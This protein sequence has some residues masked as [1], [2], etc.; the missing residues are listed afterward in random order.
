MKS[1]MTLVKYE[2]QKIFKKKSVIFALILALFVSI[3]SVCGTLFGDYYLDGRLFES[4]YEAMVKDRDYARSL[5][6]RVI[7]TGL[8]LEAAAA[9]ATIPDNAPVY[10]ATDEYQQNARTYSEIYN[11]ARQIYS[12]PSMRFNIESLSGL[13]QEQAGQFYHLQNEKISQAVNNT[14]MSDAA[15]EIVL[16]RAAQIKTPLTFSYTDGYTRFFAVLYTSGLIAAFVTAI[17]VAPLF[18]GEYTSGVDQLILSS[19]HGKGILIGAKLFTG[20]SL[21]VLLS[22]AFTLQCYLQCMLTF[23]FDGG[24]TPIQIYLS[25]CVYPVTLGHAALLQSICVI[26]ACL[27]TAAVT[28]LLSAK[29]KSPFAVII[30]VALLLIVPMLMNVPPDKPLLPYQLFYLLPSNMMPF[31]SITRIIHYELFGLVIPPYVMMP[32]FSAMCASVLTPYAFRAFK[33]HQ[34]A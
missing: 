1:F 4:N 20:F 27:F 26:F 33:R 3:I 6:G 7:D 2:Y 16:K 23:G 29:L 19:K 28:M 12:T 10:Q 15:K 34:I 13:S 5:N 17:C 32:V 30:P 22:I 9:Y 14:L 21:A 11:I 8:L 31:W 25:L 24:N 18:A